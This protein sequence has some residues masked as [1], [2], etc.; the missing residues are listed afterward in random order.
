MAVIVNISFLI[1]VKISRAHAE[2]NIWICHVMDSPSIY[3]LYKECVY[4]ILR[5]NISHLHK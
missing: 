1:S 4:Y 2:W 5:N 3:I